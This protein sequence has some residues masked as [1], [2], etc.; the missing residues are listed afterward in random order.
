MEFVELLFVSIGVSAVL[1][2][3]FKLLCLVK[4]VFPKTWYPLPKSFFSSMGQ[5]AGESSED[6][7]GKDRKRRGSES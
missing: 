7:G 2:F 6:R 4:M 1:F 5:W 3:G